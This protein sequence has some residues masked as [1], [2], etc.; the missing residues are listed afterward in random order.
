[1]QI[2]SEMNDFFLTEKYIALDLDNIIRCKTHVSDLNLKGE[3][4]VIYSDNKMLNF[5]CFMERW[6]KTLLG[7]L[8]LRFIE[9]KKSNKNRQVM[10][11]F[12]DKI[13]IKHARPPS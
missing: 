8:S 2:T 5:V 13:Y 7:C 6:N 4:S 11:A 12:V 3:R 1:M 9:R 10:Y